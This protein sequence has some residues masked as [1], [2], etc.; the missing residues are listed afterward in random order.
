VQCQ[1][2]VSKNAATRF[3]TL[4]FIVVVCAYMIDLLEDLRQKWT[5]YRQLRFSY[6]NLESWRMVQKEM[7]LV[8]NPRQ[9]NELA[10]SYGKSRC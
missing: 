4:F 8:I 2:I 9:G 7:A 1:S 5:Y 10:F 6:V 3:R